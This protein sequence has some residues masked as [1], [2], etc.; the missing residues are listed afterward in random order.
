MAK[1][2]EDGKICKAITKY[3]MKTGGGRGLPGEFFSYH[4]LPEFVIP[5]CVE[6]HQKCIF[7]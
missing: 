7:R 3:S 4:I 6:V 1:E 2:Q 5:I